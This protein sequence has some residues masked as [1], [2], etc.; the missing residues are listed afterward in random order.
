[1]Q[2]QLFQNQI[3]AKISAA[4]FKTIFFSKLNV[5]EYPAKA[6]SEETG[7]IGFLNSQDNLHIIKWTITIDNYLFLKKDI[8]HRNYQNFGLFNIRQRWLCPK[9]KC[10]KFFATL[11]SYFK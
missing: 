1:M 10:P 3:S 9:L 8:C 7:K 5:K 2:N 11:F 4:I 6:F